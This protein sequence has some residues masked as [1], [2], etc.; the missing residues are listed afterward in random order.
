MTINVVVVVGFVYRS[1]AKFV[2][3]KVLINFLFYL[4]F[5]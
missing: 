1:N 5:S 3:A 2:N 4:S